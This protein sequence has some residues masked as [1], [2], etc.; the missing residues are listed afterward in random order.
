MPLTSSFHKHRDKDGKLSGSKA[1]TP[2]VSWR[3]TEQCRH[4]PEITWDKITPNKTKPQNILARQ[5]FSLIPFWISTYFFHRIC[6]KYFHP[7]IDSQGGKILLEKITFCKLQV[8]ANK[9]LKWDASYIPM[10]GNHHIAFAHYEYE[11]II[12]HSFMMKIWLWK[13]EMS[14]SIKSGFTK[15][16][17]LIFSPALQNCLIVFSLWACQGFS[18]CF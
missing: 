17:K 8:T 1:I 2:S 6:L 16:N 4:H 5:R 9:D 12:P 13:I 14:S 7:E 15:L 18:H 10:T 3:L 11:W